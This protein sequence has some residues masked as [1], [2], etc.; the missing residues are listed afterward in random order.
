MTSEI[1]CRA[2][3]RIGVSFPNLTSAIQNA[4]DKEDIGAATATSAFV[5]SLGGATGVALSGAVLTARL[6]ALLPGG[7]PSVS[8]GGPIAGADQAGVVAAYRDA[9]SSTFLAG[10]AVVA[11]ACIVVA[12]SP[13]R[14]L[15][16]TPQS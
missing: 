5:R 15:T 6:Q 1:P 7:V 2:E 10:A 9:L 14:P 11:I 12:L 8:L 16:G 13:E 4:V 3:A